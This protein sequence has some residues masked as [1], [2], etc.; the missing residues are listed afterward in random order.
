MQESQTGLKSLQTYVL[1]VNRTIKDGHQYKKR[2][3]FPMQMIPYR[4]MIRHKVIKKS[5]FCTVLFNF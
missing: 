4:F 2:T 3:L 5:A 1:E